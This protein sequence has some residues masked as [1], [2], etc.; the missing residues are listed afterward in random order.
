MDNVLCKCDEV[1]FRI[2]AGSVKGYFCNVNRV[3]IRRINIIVLYCTLLILNIY[4]VLQV[5][6]D[7]PIWIVFYAKWIH[8]GMLYKRVLVFC[9]S[10]MNK[11]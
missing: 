3:Q 9:K 1:N 6:R 5:R 8:V 2:L 11:N 4:T 10:C 7:M